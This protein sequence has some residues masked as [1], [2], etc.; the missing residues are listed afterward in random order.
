MSDALVWLVVV[1][2]VFDWIVA[3]ILGWT[4]YRYPSILT[5]RERFVTAVMLAV[6]ATVASGL[7]FVRFGLWSLD[8]GQAIALLCL[9]LI[10]TSA[11]SV[12]WL[13]LLVTGRFRLPPIGGE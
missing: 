10:L 4:A 3:V 2:P 13:F 9:A 11:P 12:L 6:V 5:L 8:N 1:L 7:G